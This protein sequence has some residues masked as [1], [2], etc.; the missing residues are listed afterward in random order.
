MVEP[1]HQPTPR[2]LPRTPM[3]VEEIR[4]EY[5]IE[6]ARIDWVLEH[7]TQA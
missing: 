7:Y 2:Q 5:L 1:L 4:D 3:T 6:A